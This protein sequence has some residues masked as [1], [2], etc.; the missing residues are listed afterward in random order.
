MGTLGGVP[1][2]GLRGLSEGLSLD[3]ENCLGPDPTSSTYQLG[4][5]R[6]VIKP[7][8][9]SVCP[10]VQWRIII[11]PASQ[12]CHDD[13]GNQLHLGPWIV[14]EMQQRLR[15][16]AMGLPRARVSAQN[17]RVP[18]AGA[19]EGSP[20]ENLAQSSAARQF[21]LELIQEP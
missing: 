8:C 12:G 14:P 16:P 11:T 15:T 18:S 3:S 7:P 17:P 6:H 5:L 2:S 4:D 20:H 10:S 21:F 9:T 19:E 1:I 13:K